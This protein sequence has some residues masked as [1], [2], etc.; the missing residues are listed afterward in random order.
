[1]TFKYKNATESFVWIWLPENTQPIVAGRIDKKKNNYR[2]T[3]AASYLERKNAIPLSPFELPLNKGTF[4]PVGMNNIHSCLRDAAPDAWGRRLLNYQYADLSLNELDYMLLSG[5]NRIGALDFQASSKEYIPRKTNN[6]SLND[7]LVA[8]EYIEKNKILPAGL[9]YV[10]IYGTSVGGAR[11]KALVKD[12]AKQT[13]Y[14]AKFSSTT[15]TYNVIKSE[16]ISMRLAK[17]VNIKVPNVFLKTA[18]GKDVLLVE[19]F[20]RKKT[21]NAIARKLMLSGLSILGLNELE[22]R[23]ASYCDFADIIRKQFKS[24]KENL[25]EL[26]KRL[27]FNILIGNNDDHARNYSAFWDGS[28]LELTPAYDIC[29]QHRVGL[30]ATQAMA[31]EG[32]RGNF[33]TLKNA[34]SVCENFQ[35]S[36]EQAEKI[37]ESMLDT[38]NKKWTTV[39]NE[40]KLTTLER[41]Q[42]WEKSVLNPFCFY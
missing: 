38:I 3:Y 35:L 20:D 14:I 12:D 19:R 22:A 10:L 1:M 6:V 27:I 9:Q 26:Y 41:M 29:P 11:P 15:D 42:L 2:F 37:I 36:S 33:S 8:T 23:Y 16:Y 25:T 13:E 39:C 28:S 5:S 7:I 18:S 24:P 34:I 4:D 31:I 30:E 32:V 21:K 17:L 40:A